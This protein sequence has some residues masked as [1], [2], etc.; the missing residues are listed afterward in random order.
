MD[1][2][3]IAHSTAS[4]ITDGDAIVQFVQKILHKELFQLLLQLLLLTMSFLFYLKLFTSRNY[5][6]VYV[7]IS[8]T[9]LGI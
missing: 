2:K 8:A 9:E 5:L 3:K 4:T 6:P 7:Y 1:E